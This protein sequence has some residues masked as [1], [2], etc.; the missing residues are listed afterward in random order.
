[1]G[2]YEIDHVLIDYVLFVCLFLAMFNAV[3][4]LSIATKRFVKEGLKSRLITMVYYFILFAGFFIVERMIRP[5]K[6]VIAMPL[7]IIINYMIPVLM[8]VSLVMII[9]LVAAISK[10]KREQREKEEKPKKKE[11]EYERTWIDDAAGTIGGDA[12]QR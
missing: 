4:F 12:S 1:M 9:A 8:V 2:N 6:V 7:R 3:S 11:E 10:E 5:E